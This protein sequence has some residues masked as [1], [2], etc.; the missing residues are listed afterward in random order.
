VQSELRRRKPSQLHPI[1]PLLVNS[2]QVILDNVI[3]LRFQSLVFRW[4]GVAQ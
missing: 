3:E 2:S 4:G 1:L